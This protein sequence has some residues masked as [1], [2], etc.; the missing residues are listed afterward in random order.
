MF[1]EK[2]KFIVV[3]EE[4]CVLIAMFWAVQSVRIIPENQD[5][6]K[7]YAQIYEIFK[8]SMFDTEN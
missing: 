8:T 5:N 7:L 1:I 4:L 6:Q 3:V 2:K